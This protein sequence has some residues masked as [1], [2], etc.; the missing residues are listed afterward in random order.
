MYNAQTVIFSLQQVKTPVVKMPVAITD[1]CSSTNAATRKKMLTN[2][3]THSITNQSV[4][5]NHH[6]EKTEEPPAIKHVPQPAITQKKGKKE[7]QK[8][9]EKETEKVVGA[10]KGKKAMSERG[11]GRKT[12]NE[13]L[14]E[15]SSK[16]S[17]SQTKR[18]PA[19]ENKVQLQK[20]KEKQKKSA[21]QSDRCVSEDEEVEASA[22]KVIDIANNSFKTSASKSKLFSQSTATKTSLEK[23]CVI[24]Q[25]AYMYMYYNYKILIC[26]QLNFVMYTYFMCT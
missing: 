15:K 5:F 7:E 20:T 26:A 8:T 2:C 1:S 10:G 18:R 9:D 4:T 13:R 14:A 21:R 22:L 24:C 17:V 23:V 25:C 6:G 16:M 3:N 12:K 11:K 19:K